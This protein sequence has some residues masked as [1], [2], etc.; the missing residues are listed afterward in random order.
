[1]HRDIRISAHMSSLVPGRA[2]RIP[3]AHSSPTHSR[4]LFQQTETGHAPALTIQSAYP[5]APQGARG[6][7]LWI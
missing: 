1:M 4:H 6:Y 2:Q 7:A 3:S 5:R